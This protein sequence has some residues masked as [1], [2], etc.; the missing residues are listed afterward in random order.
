M[1]KELLHD[2]K[3]GS[4][5]KWK[6]KVTKAKAPSFMRDYYEQMKA[7]SPSPI[8]NLGNGGFIGKPTKDQNNISS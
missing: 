4:G 2:S 3:F 6:N 5:S 8:K 7:L 1:E